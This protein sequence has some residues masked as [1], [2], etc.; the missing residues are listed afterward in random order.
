[1]TGASGFIGSHLC[2]Q[3]LEGG[4]DVHA[5]SRSEQTSGAVRWWA[6]DVCDTEATLA[7]VRSVKPEL[8]FHLASHV[9]GSR[10]R[11]AV[12]PTLHANLLSTVNIL[13]AAAEAGCTVLLTILPACTSVIS[14]GVRPRSASRVGR[15]A[16]AQRRDPRRA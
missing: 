15:R 2:Q 14:A 13:L 6:T 8:I 11:D 1:M 10:D 5:V 4:A 7:L 12:L 16:A 3:L 9:S